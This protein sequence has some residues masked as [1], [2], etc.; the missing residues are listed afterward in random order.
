MLIAPEYSNKPVALV[1]GDRADSRVYDVATGYQFACAIDYYNEGAY[2]WGSNMY[3]Q[4]GDSTLVDKYV[5]TAVL[6]G[7]MPSTTVSKIS[8]G[9][10]HACAI[11]SDN[12]AYCWGQ[13][14]SGQLGNNAV[15]NSSTPVAVAQGDMPSLIVK[16]ITTGNSYSCAIASDDQVY[17]W[18]ANSGGQ[19]GNGTLTNSRV[20]KL[21][22]LGQ[23]PTLTAKTVSAGTDT[24]CALGSDDHGY[25]WG[26]NSNSHV[27]NGTLSLYIN[28]PAAISIGQMPSLTIKSI[29]AGYYSM[30][31]IGS[32]DNTYC[33]G[34]NDLGQVGTDYHSGLD[35]QTPRLIIAADE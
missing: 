30:C 11:A 13:G 8:A 34:D 25:C 5:P 7:N 18:G 27:G 24:T 29:V 4:L 23:R 17:C 20:P 15:A 21:V 19:L 6:Q 12:Q 28:T 9:L 1:L 31:A 14:T 2:C 16:Q 22:S 33:W 32:D 26:R 3:G 35:N 10:Y